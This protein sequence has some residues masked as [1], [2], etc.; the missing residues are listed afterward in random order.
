MLAAAGGLML[1]VQA[2]RA[3]TDEQLAAIERLGDL[4]GVALHCDALPQTQRM[5]R[6]L[7]LHLP[8]R[9]QLGELFD[10]RTNDSF[11]RFIREE[12]SCPAPAVLEEQVDDAIA[13]LERVY[14]G[15]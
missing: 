4:N 5:K 6:A 1:L 8:K 15:Q 10:Y 3:A 9:R 14:G 2:A 7:V 13:E 11:M 12:A